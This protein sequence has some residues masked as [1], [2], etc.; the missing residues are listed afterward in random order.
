MRNAFRD[1]WSLLAVTLAGL[2]VAAGVDEGAAAQRALDAKE[3]AWG[4]QLIQYVYL[5]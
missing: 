5:P 3:F 1:Y 4:A 2:P